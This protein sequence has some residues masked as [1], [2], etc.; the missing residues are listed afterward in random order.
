MPP[1][2]DFFSS[3]NSTT[4]SFFDVDWCRES[5]SNVLISFSD[6]Y[7]GLDLHDLGVCCSQNLDLYE[8]LLMQP[9]LIAFER[10]GYSINPAC[11]ALQTDLCIF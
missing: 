2:V 6:K 10:L 1:R 9:V 3:I 11:E 5:T 4:S 8:G 7:F